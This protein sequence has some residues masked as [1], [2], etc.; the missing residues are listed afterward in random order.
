MGVRVL[1]TKHRL[2]LSD[3][4]EITKLRVVLAV[5]KRWCDDGNRPLIRKSVLAA[6]AVATSCTAGN[7]AVPL[8]TALARR[9]DRRPVRWQWQI[10]RQRERREAIFASFSSLT[11]S[12]VSID[13]PLHVHCKYW[14]FH[15]F[16]STGMILLSPWLMWRHYVF[17]RSTITP[18]PPLQIG[19]VSRVLKFRNM[20]K[21]QLITHFDETCVL[22][23]FRRCNSL[24]IF[25]NIFWQTIYN[26]Q[27]SV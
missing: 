6:R 8:A 13:R 16:E 21:S 11:F 24:F 7:A 22:I 5:R 1:S 4:I 14:S 23:D 2:R 18:P 26:L 15:S 12:F 17:S 3:A 9:R 25:R 10:V 19:H 27:S 20:F